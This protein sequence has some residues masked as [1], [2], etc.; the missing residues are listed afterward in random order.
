MLAGVPTAG[1]PPTPAGLN[2]KVLTQLG[3]DFAPLF[4]FDSGETIYPSSVEAFLTT[5]VDGKPAVTLTDGTDPIVR[6]CF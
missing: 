2:L 4:L 6:H 1:L 5:Q 3:Q